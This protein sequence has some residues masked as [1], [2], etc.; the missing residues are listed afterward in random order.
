VAETDGA[1]EAV[2]ATRTRALLRTAFLLTGDPE[3]AR[4]LLQSALE[5]VTRRLGAI[6]DPQALEAYLRA[7]MATTAANQRRRM[8]HRELPTATLVDEEGRDPTA[9]AD[10]RVAV[11]AA[12]RAL[13]PEQRAVIVLRFYEDLTEA[14]T[15]QVLGIALGTVKSRTSRAL[16]ALRASGLALSQEVT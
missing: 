7:T 8:W 13:P 6:R 9:A 11:V 3:S 10:S 5:R 2:L 1:L 12:L 15:A 4:D 16:D 14:Q